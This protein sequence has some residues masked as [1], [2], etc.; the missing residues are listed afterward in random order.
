[1]HMRSPRRIRWPQVGPMAGPSGR[2]APPYQM[3]PSILAGTKNGDAVLSRVPRKTANQK[4]FSLCIGR[5][6]DPNAGSVSDWP[7]ATP[8][9]VPQSKYVKAVSRVLHTQENALRRAVRTAARECEIRLNLIMSFP[10][11][12]LRL[13]LS[14]DRYVAA[15]TTHYPSPPGKSLGITWSFVTIRG[16][17]QKEHQGPDH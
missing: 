17:G 16:V 5:L 1:M 10:P 7:Q 6:M 9:P 4:S 2:T 14:F 11:P 15:T 8:T 3:R 12:W 13:R